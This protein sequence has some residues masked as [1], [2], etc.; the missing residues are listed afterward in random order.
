MAVDSNLQRGSDIA[1]MIWIVGSPLIFTVGVFG[2]IMTIIVLTSKRIKQTSSTIFLAF[3]AAADLFMISL[4]LPRWWLIYL[5]RFDVRHIHDIVCK[6]QFFSSY[7]SGGYS[8][9]LLAA[10]TIER[11]LYT[12]RPFKVRTICTARIATIISVVLALI[13]C[14]I[15]GHILFGI[16]LHEITY[17]EAS[18]NTML[19]ALDSNER[20]SNTCQK[21][22]NQFNDAES[23][24]DAKMKFMPEDECEGLINSSVQERSVNSVVNNVSNKV[25]KI[26][27][28]W[29]D[30]SRYGHYFSEKHQI[31]ATVCYL[32][33][34]EIIFFVGG[35]IIV[36]RLHKNKNLRMRMKTKYTQT[37]DCKATLDNR[38]TQITL[39]L[40]LVNI[41]FV[42]TTSPAYIFLMGKSSWVDEDTGMT[43]AQEISW[44]VVNILLCTNHAI[45]FILYFLS[46]YRFR[47]QVLER[48][49]CTKCGTSVSLNQPKLSS[50]SN[51]NDINFTE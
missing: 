27:V 41:V 6:V 11:T 4:I 35:V 19:F 44:A 32:I 5:F 46:G 20:F 47:R 24:A 42:F 23:D 12:I 37:S 18:N 3:L 9:A 21:L 45:N 30:N 40:L 22:L 39:T 7:F 48:F 15:H 14:V 8:A 34:P 17:D 49:R 51:S 26:K 38:A 16:T 10:V 29:Y 25:R 36:K 50:V 13:L 31:V 33:I 1:R 28:C 43:A 2:N